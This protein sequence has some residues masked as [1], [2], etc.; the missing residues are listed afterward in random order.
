MISFR[1]QKG[2]IEFLILA[3]IIIGAFVLVGGQYIFDTLP[4]NNILSPS[5]TPG[6]GGDPGGNNNN[7]N[8]EENEVATPGWSIKEVASSNCDD[9]K[10]ASL[11]NIEF[12]G[13][14]DGYAKTKSNGNFP[15]FAHEFKKPKQS[16][17]FTLAN[18]EGYGTNLWKIELFEGGSVSNK[19]GSGGT[20]KASKN[21]QPTGCT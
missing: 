1:S 21:M 19:V 18:E 15:A 8:P 11:V 16:I 12:T 5:I 3:V 4:K 20:V 13:T 14:A 9:E 7:G 17:T 6:A 2:D 10:N